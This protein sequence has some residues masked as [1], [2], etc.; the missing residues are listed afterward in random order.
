MYVVFFKYIFVENFNTSSRSHQPITWNCNDKI[1]GAEGPTYGAE[2]NK[3]LQIIPFPSSSWE[4]YGLQWGQNL[5]IL[6]GK[7]HPKIELQRLPKIGI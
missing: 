6:T 2:K 3:H 4:Q 5:R 1:L 7:K